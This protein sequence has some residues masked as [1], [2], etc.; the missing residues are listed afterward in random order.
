M[1]REREK[2]MGDA[3]IDCAGGGVGAEPPR[4]LLVSGGHV[5]ATNSHVIQQLLRAYYAN[6]LKRAERS[7]SQ[8]AGRSTP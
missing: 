8:P 3:L 1:R 4:P 5:R 2:S 6:A 7:A